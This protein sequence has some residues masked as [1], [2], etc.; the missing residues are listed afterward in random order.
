LSSLAQVSQDIHNLQQRLQDRTREFDQLQTQN[1]TGSAE[2][3][4][5]R[6]KLA[7]LVKTNDQEKAELE[8]YM[9]KVIT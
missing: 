8:A 5:L 1:K 6:G 2:N 7:E 3:H 4:L 9:T